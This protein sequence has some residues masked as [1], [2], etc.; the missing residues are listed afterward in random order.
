MDIISTWSEFSSGKGDAAAKQE[1]GP[2]LDGTY[3]LFEG[4]AGV[5]C[6]YADMA[7]PDKFTGFP[8]FTDL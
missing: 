4:A 1:E 3:G 8:L 6:F 7:F 5:A 2:R